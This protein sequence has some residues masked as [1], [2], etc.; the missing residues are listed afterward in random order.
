MVLLIADLFDFF[1]RI[2]GLRGSTGLKAIDL[3]VQHP[4]DL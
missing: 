4:V 1:D 2:T 3:L